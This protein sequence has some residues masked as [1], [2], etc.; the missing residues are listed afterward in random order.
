MPLPSKSL[1]L[2]PS[3]PISLDNMPISPIYDIRSLGPTDSGFVQRR[4]K[5]PFGALHHFTMKSK[6]LSI[7]EEAE[8]YEFYCDRRGGVD[9]FQLFDPGESKLWTD[10]YLG[11]G[12]GNVTDYA[13]KASG[14]SGVTLTVAGVVN[15]DWTLQEAGGMDGQD[16]ARFNVAPTGMIKAKLTG[17]RYFPYV[18]FIQKGLDRQ[19]LS[20]AL[21]TA[22]LEMQEVWQ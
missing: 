6:G 12:D 16:V 1:L 5:T 3:L 20:Y 11:T 22:G 21:R 9:A 2:F 15:N 14:T 10:I 17:R 13:I 18:V 8:L 19:R 7:A 4:N